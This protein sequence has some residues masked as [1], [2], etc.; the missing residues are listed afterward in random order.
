MMMMMV[1]CRV[2][3]GVKII[4][5]DVHNIMFPPSFQSKSLEVTDFSAHVCVCVCL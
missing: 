3:G 2:K 5:D 4:K 1:M